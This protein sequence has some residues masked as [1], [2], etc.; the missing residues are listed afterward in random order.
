[1]KM[2]LIRQSEAI[3]IVKQSLTDALSDEQIGHINDM[4]TEATYKYSCGGSSNCFISK[5]DIPGDDESYSLQLL[6][7]LLVGAGWKATYRYDQ[8]DGECLVI[9]LPKVSN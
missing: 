5:R 9:D 1:M 3:N 2:S 8:R 7:T 4:L 6:A